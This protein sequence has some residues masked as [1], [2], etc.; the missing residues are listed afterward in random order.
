[1]PMMQSLRSA[2]LISAV[3]WALGGLGGCASWWPTADRTVTDSA[4]PSGKA[5][6]AASGRAASAPPALTVQAPAPAKALLEQHLNLARAAQIRSDDA[7]DDTEL[8][9]LIASTPAQARDLLQTEGWF[10]P[11]VTVSRLPSL[12]SQ[13]NLTTGA[14]AEWLVK[15]NPGPRT[16][17]QSLQLEIDGP[18]KAALDAKEPAALA[19]LSSL[20]A[21]PAAQPGTPFRNAEWTQTKLTV[22]ERLRLAGYA[23]ALL[24]QSAADVDVAAHRAELHIS[25][26]SGP[27]FVSGAL[28]IEGLKHHDASTIEH[29]AGFGPGTALTDTLLLDYQDRLLKSGLFDTAVVSY[30]PDPAQAQAAVVSVKLSERALQQAQVGVGYSANTGQRVSLEHTHRRPLGYPLVVHNKAEWG[31]DIQSFSGD[32]STHPGEGFYR[33]LAGVQ[34]ERVLSPTDVV[35]S[36]RLRLGRTT[37]TPRFE[38]LYYVEALNSRRSDSIGVIS[39]QAV[40]GNL[41][42]VLRDLDSVLLPTR[43]ISLAVQGGLGGAASRTGRSGPFLRA[44]GRLT[45]YLPLGGQWYGQARLEAGQIFKQSAVQVPDALGF[46]AGG[47]DSVRGYAYRSLAPSLVRGTTSTTISGE[48][49]LTGSLEIA[50]PISANLPAVWIAAFIDAGR[51]SARWSDYSAAFGYGLGVRWR[52]PIGPL[53][54]DLAWGDELRRLRLHFSVGIAF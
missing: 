43:G 24:S 44:Y 26:A 25:L 19:L 7:L 36:E 29:L 42:V 52:S 49:L 6:A 45:G 2:I 14:R 41:N 48:V 27:R 4:A 28:Q 17:V 47:D 5:A 38:R 30:D 8:A 13:P 18:L 32:I 21:P 22:L 50:H 39:A 9:R 16:T 54:A 23:S 46:R 53:R 11:E 37:D 51:A 34:I 10:E 1:M 33:N 15:V 20:S 31:R 12:A 3:A 40:S 35:L